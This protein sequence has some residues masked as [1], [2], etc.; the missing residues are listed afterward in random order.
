[1]WL[2]VD[3]S[4]FWGNPFS[5][6]ALNGSRADRLELLGPGMLQVACRASKS[7]ALSLLGKW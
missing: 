2:T 7:T 3:L 1:M 6:N 5:E 4:L